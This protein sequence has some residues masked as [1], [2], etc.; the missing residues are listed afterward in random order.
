MVAERPVRRLQIPSRAGAYEVLIA[1]GAC[2]PDAFAGDLLERAPHVAVVTQP[3]VYDLHGARL[4]AALPVEPS[5]LTVLT[6]GQGERAKSLR[7]AE[8]LWRSLLQR[9]FTRDSV[10]VALGGGVVGDMAGFVAATL[11]RGVAWVNVPTTLLAQ[12]DAAVGGKTGIN[13]LEGRNLVGAFHP[14]RLVVVDTSLLKTL[15]ARQV[16]SGLGEVVKYGI[17]VD[18]EVWNLC[19]TRLPEGACDQ[20][21]VGA[22]LAAKARVVAADEHEGGLRRSLN[23]GHTLGHAIE[24]AAPGRLGHGEAVAVGLRFVLALSRRLQRCDEAFAAAAEAMLDRT[25]LVRSVP[26]GLTFADLEAFLQRD[27]KVSRRGLTWM[28][29]VA[30]GRCEAVDGTPRADLTAAFAAVAGP[31]RPLGTARNCR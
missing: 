2:Q 18:E 9:G 30:P 29:P 13:V 17:G 15:P 20:D 1:E 6:M 5:R 3:N 8:R 19:L 26:A 28:L 25:N 12:V 11:L 24:A 22:C 27:K 16:R 7:S 31:V 21:V 14:P 23:L 10:V 4:V